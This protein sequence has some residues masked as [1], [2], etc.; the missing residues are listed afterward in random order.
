M[1]TVAVSVKGRREEYKELTRA[2][3]LE[4]ATLRFA[5]DGYAASTIDDIA[6]SARVSK[7]AVY[8]HFADKAQLF[9]AAFRE[10]QAQLLT[11]V[12]EAAAGREDPWDQLD[13]AIAAYLD[14]T[15]ADPTQRA[16]LQQAPQAIGAERCREIDE[17]LAL[18]FL[19]TALNN[20]DQ[21]RT[22]ATP[23]TEMLAR[24]LFT[25]LCEAAMTA[26]AAPDTAQAQTEA[27]AA[28]QTLTSGLR[29][30]PQ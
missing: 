9:E 27:R 8:Y 30:N 20:L 25:S 1:I 28:L 14:H 11:K 10:R 13:T 22:L 15:V 3:L 5:Q 26:G 6:R 4:A 23:R 29:G 2:A 12:A 16:L 24:V 17:E 21:T 19:L 18:P 7:G